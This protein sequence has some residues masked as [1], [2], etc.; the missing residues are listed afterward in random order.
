M[1]LPHFLKDLFKTILQQRNYHQPK[2]VMKS[3]I[4]LA[5]SLLNLVA[6]ILFATY[7]ILS[8]GQEIVYVDSIRLMN[9]YKGIDE[10]KNE[11]KRKAQILNT[12]LDTLKSELNSK[13]SEYE[14]SKYKMTSKEKRLMEELLSTKED[15]IIN[16][17][18][19]VSEKIQKENTDLLNKVQSRVNEFIK[20][21][22][23]Q[24]GYTIIMAATQYGNIVY[25][26]N[27]IDITDEVIDGLNREYSR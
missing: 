25:A 26:Q 3:K 22:G 12:N 2:P 7:Y 19:V 5:I 17:Q 4:Q 16:Y 18:Q 10:V 11:M 21:Y 9:K 1:L 23:E 27:E 13:I 8:S 24:N 14:L 20:R 15:Q 6:V